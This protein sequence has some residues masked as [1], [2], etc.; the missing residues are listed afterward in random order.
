MYVEGIAK[1]T[2][3]IFGTQCTLYIVEYYVKN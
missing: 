2:N 1:Q 3:D